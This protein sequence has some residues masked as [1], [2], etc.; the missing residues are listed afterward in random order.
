MNKLIVIGNGISET[1]CNQHI[2]LFWAFKNDYVNLS[3]L[4]FRT[5]YNKKSFC[6][7]VIDIAQK[8]I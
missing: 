5:K 1:N 4:L 6:L 2:M 7:Q 8:S 3:S